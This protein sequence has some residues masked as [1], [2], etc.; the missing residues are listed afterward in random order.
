MGNDFIAC[1]VGI[2]T[3]QAIFRYMEGRSVFAG[4]VDLVLLSQCV[5][6]SYFLVVFSVEYRGFAMPC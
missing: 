4:Y 5:T 2:G 6:P 3:V 1:T